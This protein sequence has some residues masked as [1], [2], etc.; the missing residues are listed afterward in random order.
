MGDGKM[1]MPARACLQ[2]S[3]NSENGDGNSYAEKVLN[4]GGAR[5]VLRTGAIASE[6]LCENGR[7]MPARAQRNGGIPIATIAN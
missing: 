3:A 7:T 5:P 2:N 4:A 1:G 6:E